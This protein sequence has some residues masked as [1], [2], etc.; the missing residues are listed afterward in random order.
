MV[1]D[2]LYTAPNLP[3]TAAGAI[4][5]MYLRINGGH[6]DS[7]KMTAAAAAKALQEVTC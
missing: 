3:L 7:S 1:V 5:A 6:N 2:M 4:S